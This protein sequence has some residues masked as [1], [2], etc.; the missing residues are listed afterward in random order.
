[1]KKQRLLPVQ[2]ALL[3][4]CGGLMLST[5]VSAAEAGT[6]TFNGKVTDETCQ[7]TTGSSGDFTVDLATAKVADLAQAGATAMPSNFRIAV[8]QC[9]PTVTNVR[10]QF[11]YDANLVDV[12]SGVLK[13]QLSG[14]TSATNV[15][16]QLYNYAD[17][18]V[19]K[20]GDAGAAKS[21]TVQDGAAEMIYGVQYYATGKSTAGLVKSQVKYQLSYN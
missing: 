5:T 15:G 17:N 21:F 19:I 18:S 2:A 12:S 13:N 14:D 7:V 20:P 10:A 16:L 9:S 6:I 1:M 3:S 11:L 4:V 8:N